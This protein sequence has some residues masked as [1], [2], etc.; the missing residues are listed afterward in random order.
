M[1]ATSVIL[2]KT[3]STTMRM[4]WVDPPFLCNRLIG[5]NDKF[6]DRHGFILL[7]Y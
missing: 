1:N 2:E 5:F 4:I 6:Y 7:G 3:H